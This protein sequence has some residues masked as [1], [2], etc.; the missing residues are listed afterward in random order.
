LHYGEL[1]SEILPTQAH[2]QKLNAAATPVI[3]VRF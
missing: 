1:T 2:D 3:I